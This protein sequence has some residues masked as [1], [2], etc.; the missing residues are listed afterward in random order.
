MITTKDIQKDIAEGTT[1]IVVKDGFRYYTDSL[2]GTLIVPLTSIEETLETYEKVFRNNHTIQHNTK[3]LP[4]VSMYIGQPDTGKTYKALKTAAEYNITP[5]FKMCHENLN[6]ET[7][8]EDFKLVDGK[9]VFEES[10]AL[11]MLSGTEPGIIIL[12]EFNT[13]RTG[14]IKTLQPIFD[15]TS[16][17]F[18]YRGKIYNKNMQCKFIVTLNDKDKG[19]SVVPDAILSRSAIEWFEPIDNKTIAQWTHVPVEWV[20]NLQN[21][22]KILG[23]LSIFGTRQVK[24]LHMKSQKVITNHLYGLCKMKQV[25]TKIIETLPMQALLTK[26]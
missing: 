1:K 13:L 4:R 9:P 11:K 25:D 5:L 19:I 10:L 22:Y 6:L 15:D 12:D 24:A 18:E 23:L 7:L 14:V 20:S 2:T 26:L 16:T 8:I 21:I 3:Q 17:T